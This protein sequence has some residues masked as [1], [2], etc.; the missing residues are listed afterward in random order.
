MTFYPRR[1]AVVSELSPDEVREVCEMR[2]ALE[3]M[4]LTRAMPNITAEDL[5]RAEEILDLTDEQTDEE[6][7]ARWRELNWRFHEALYRPANRPRLLVV[8]KKL[9]T[10]FDRYLRLHLS[11]MDYREKGQQEHRRLFECCKRGDVD[12]TVE[13]LRNHIRTVA[14]MLLV[15]LDEEGDDGA[16]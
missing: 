14:A 13:I 1:G 5:R 2:E 8:I 9:Q 7:V 15:Y 12:G 16:L 6:L 4:A 3:V 11:P 10:N